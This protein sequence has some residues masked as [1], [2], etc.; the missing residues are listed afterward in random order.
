MKRI[1]KITRKRWIRTTMPRSIPG[2]EI[3]SPNLRCST[4]QKNWARGFKTYIIYTPFL[5]NFRFRS[6]IHWSIT[7]S[8]FIHMIFAC[9]GWWRDEDE[10]TPT[11]YGHEFP[12]HGAPACDIYSLLY[13]EEL[14][15]SWVLLE[16]F[17]VQKSTVDQHSHPP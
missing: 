7:H 11:P 6:R 5:K 8:L 17:H 15:E 9:S 3:Q 2:F 4:P 1:S 16:P 10:C 12:H 14:L 13:L